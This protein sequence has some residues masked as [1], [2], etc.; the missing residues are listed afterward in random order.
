[1]QVAGR[2]MGER[3]G[4]L[5]AGATGSGGTAQRRGLVAVGDGPG[6]DGHVRRLDFQV[7]SGLVHVV[8]VIG[9]DARLL[10]Q[11]LRTVVRFDKFAGGVRSVRGL[12]V[13]LG[14]VVYG[15]HGAVLAVQESVERAAGG[16]Q[17]RVARVDA[18]RRGA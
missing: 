12:P 18:V 10:P 17:G 1:M 6:V 11:Q 5:A 15:L 9:G 2:L 3:A 14:F 13:Q 7:G 8:H 4:V 16:G